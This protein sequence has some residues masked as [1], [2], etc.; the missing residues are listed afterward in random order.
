[1]K[2]PV[3]AAAA[4]ATLEVIEE[5]GLLD[6][7]AELGAYFKNGL[8]DLQRSHPCLGEVRGLGL[9]LGATLVQVDNP[10]QPDPRRAEA[11]MYESLSRGLSFKTTMGNTLTLTP[12]LTVLESEIDR[13][14]EILDA[15]L[16]VT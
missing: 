7:A 3:G 10:T 4:L 12:P 2:S 14:L 1:E 13:A 8:I 16:A 11:V 5:E 9:F 15:S 6:R